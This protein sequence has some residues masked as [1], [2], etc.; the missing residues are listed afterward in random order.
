MKLMKQWKSG[1]RR[2]VNKIMSRNGILRQA[3]EEYDYEER[4]KGEQREFI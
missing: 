4:E 2:N 1:I 3:E